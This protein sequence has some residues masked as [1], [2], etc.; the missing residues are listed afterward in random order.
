MKDYIYISL[1]KID[2]IEG[3][4]KE[5]SI[6]LENITPKIE[7][8]N[9]LSISAETK[10]SSMENNISH[11]ERFMRNAHKRGMIKN[12]S[13]IN[14]LETDFI[15]FDN[16]DWFN[17]LFYVDGGDHAVVFYILW[18]GWQDSII[19]LTGSPKNILGEKSIRA[20]VDYFGTKGSLWQL[21]EMMKNTFKSTNL[22]NLS[23]SSNEDVSE[24]MPISRI[25]VRR[26]GF[27]GQI[28]SLNRVGS[29]SAV[30]A[31]VFCIKYLYQLP[32]AITE[33]A[34]RI[35]QV[36]VFDSQKDLPIWFSEIRDLDIDT[37][38]RKRIEKCR[39]VYIGSPIYTAS[40]W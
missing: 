15:C 10:I 26:K 32:I 33:T 30:E 40:N 31:G 2:N 13:D 4:F 9:A 39:Q 11:V 37:S 22:N 19:L 17:G 28:S 3:Q 34:F 16:S 38:L 7:I 1:Q 36:L 20:G 18:K 23:G 12:L 27:D 24:E 5:K 21:A 8:L 6:K 14:K 29:L 35:H 25:G